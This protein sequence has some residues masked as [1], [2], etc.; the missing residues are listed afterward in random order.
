VGLVRVGSSGVRD[1]E[2]AGVVGGTGEE[3]R[4]APEQSVA[5]RAFDEGWPSVCGSVPKRLFIVLR[6]I[7]MPIRLKRFSI[8]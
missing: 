4:R 6:G 5:W 2:Y 1:E 3:R 8:R 7:G